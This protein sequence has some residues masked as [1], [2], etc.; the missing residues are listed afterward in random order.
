[1]VARLGEDGPVLDA[2]AVNAVYGDN[3]SYWREVALYPD[4]MR[5][6]E[7]RLQVGNITPDIR[8]VLNIFVS[9]VT[10]ED[11]ALT[12]VLTYEDFDES[13][14]CVYRMLQSPGSTTS[15]CHTTRYYQ[16][17]VLIGEYTL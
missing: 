4:G 6:V 14:V 15:T 13:G 8:V 9:G 11:G 16:G 2:T 1:M 17:N 12:R 5:A 10:F 3:G 7:V